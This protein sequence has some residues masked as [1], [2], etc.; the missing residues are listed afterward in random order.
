MLFRPGIQELRIPFLSSFF[1]PFPLFGSEM[2]TGKMPNKFSELFLAG[3]FWAELEASPER[4]PVDDEPLLA[5]S[6]VPIAELRLDDKG[7]PPSTA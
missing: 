7:G 1:V 2:L 3:P 6:P 4:R 5:L